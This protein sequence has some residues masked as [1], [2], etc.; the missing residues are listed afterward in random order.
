M[1][2]LAACLIAANSALPLRAMQ[3]LKTAET[4]TLDDMAPAMV[5]A[6]NYTPN[7]CLPANADNMVLEGEILFRT[8]RL[9]GGHAA[10]GRLSCQS[11]HINGADNPAFHFPNASGAPGTADVSNSFFSA[12]GGNG[13]FD[14]VRIPDLSAAGKVAR[15]NP[16]ELEAFLTVL[17]VNEFAGSQPNKA[18]ITSLSQYV[19]ALQPCSAGAIKRAPDLATDMELVINAVILANKRLDRGEDEIAHMLIAGG[20]DILGLVHERFAG[21]EFAAERAKLERIS[22]DLRDLAAIDDVKARILA[23]ADVLARL[24]GVQFALQRIEARSLYNAETLRAA[25]AE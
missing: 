7:I 18:M 21:K 2:G 14:P 12:K 10:K 11:C 17:V 8:P 6:V 16:G 1:T 5:A 15:D 13:K 4:G 19:R 9:L 22:R 25:L 3:W 23:S 20:R 24:G